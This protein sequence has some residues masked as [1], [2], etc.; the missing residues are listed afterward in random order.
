MFNEAGSK[1]VRAIGN[2]LFSKSID[3]VRLVDLNGNSARTA[4]EIAE[5]Q[6]KAVNSN[7]KVYQVII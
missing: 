1:A 6:S 5:A 7:A 3:Y 2:K 4:M